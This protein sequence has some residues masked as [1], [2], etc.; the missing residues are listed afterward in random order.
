MAALNLPKR[1]AKIGGSIA[2]KTQFH[3]EEEVPAV[4]VPLS[5]L[6]LDEGD[7]N[8][9]FG[10]ADAHSR[11]FRQENDMLMPALRGAEI[12]LHDKFKGAKVTIKAGALGLKLA[13]ANVSRIRLEPLPGGVVAL[14]CTVSG[15]PEGTV[16]VL[17]LLNA[18]CTASILGGE[19]A[20]RDNE[21]QDELPLAGGGPAP[22][23]EPPD[24]PGDEP[25]E[26][27]RGAKRKIEEHKK[28]V[29]H[30]AKGRPTRH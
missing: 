12:A 8:R 25:S 1:V 5:G 13:P 16:D 7:V 3:G 24:E 29:G 23:S 19:I 17:G 30:T 21:N 20:A 14:S 22:A 26:F 18:D 9:M 10:Q 4:S 2:T 11:M 28:R 27:E 15:A 6:I